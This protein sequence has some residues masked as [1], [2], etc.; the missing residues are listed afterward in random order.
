MNTRGIQLVVEFLLLASGI[1]RAQCRH[2]EHLLEDI[3]DTEKIVFEEMTAFRT[4]QNFLT[5]LLHS[6]IYFPR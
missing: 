4:E 6:G 3:Y 5:F 1:L 2:F